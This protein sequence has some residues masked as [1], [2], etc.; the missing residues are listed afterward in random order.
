[1]ITAQTASE[2]I[3]QNLLPQIIIAIRTRSAVREILAEDIYAT[4]DQPPF[5]RVTMDGI[6]I[7]LEKNLN[8][9]YPIESMARAG[10][11]TVN[12]QN[13][14]NC[15]EVMTGA[16][17]PI[18]CNTV[19]PYEEIEI[20]NDC[21]K[22]LSPLKIESNSNIHQQGSD[23]KKGSLLLEK[24]V[25]LSPPH[26]SLIA[27]C[28]IK[29][30]KVISRIKIAIISTGDELIELGLPLESHQIYKSNPYTIKAQLKLFGI[31]ANEM[32]H[33]PDD[34]EKILNRLKK[35]LEE[36]DMLII[37][38]GVSKGKYDF[39][40]EVL[41]ELQV[42]KIFHTVKHRPG[43][44][45]F[46]GTGT[47]NQMIF[48]LPGN[49]VSALVSLRKYIIPALKHDQNC[50]PSFYVILEN[51]IVVNKDMTFFI[52]AKIIFTKDGKIIATPISG[53][54]S[55]DFY[56][57]KDSD[58]FLE[59]DNSKSKNTFNQGESHPFYYWNF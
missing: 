56:Q 51:D 29:E 44:P 43:K 40:P 50:I 30:I 12:L 39:I 41:E 36:N 38:G 20:K 58:G 42:K 24:F 26:I 19:I 49:P 34:K 55:G 9:Y 28:G 27:S 3:A 10:H 32:I 2:L 37:S 18:G 8:E 6:A 46:F 5:D 14:K 45:L 15:V 54:G 53:N 13:S 25:K 4:Y 57:L 59:I 11:P 31:S 1:M 16:P 33:L 35:A 7:S 23:Y 21:A 48:G 52:P 47:K 17:L 22:I